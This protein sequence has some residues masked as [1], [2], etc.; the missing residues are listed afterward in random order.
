M[1]R[2]GPTFAAQ[3][4]VERMVA[5]IARAINARA[6][7]GAD[8]ARLPETMD[9]AI[10][11]VRAVCDDRRQDS[12][13]ILLLDDALVVDDRPLREGGLH[14]QPLIRTLQRCRIER[15][16]LARDTEA[17]EC[18]ELIDALTV[19]RVPR[20]SPHV[21]VGSLEIA[22]EQVAEEGGAA[23]LSITTAHIEAATD[24]FLQFRSHRHG[25]IGRL[26]EL[27]W[28]LID[29]VSR[30]SRMMLPLAP[31]RSHDEYTFVH[32]VNVALLVLAQ[33][34]SFGLQG[35][36]LHGIGVAAL[37]H[38]I[39]KLSI[40]VDVLN[41]PGRLEGEEWRIM[42]M[43][44]DLGARRLAEGEAA[45]PLSILVAYEHHLRYDGQPS[46]PPVKRPRR[47]TLASQLTTVADV[48]DAI[49]TARPYRK[50][51]SRQ[52]A[53]DVLR[54]R[55]GTFHDPFLVG[56]FFRLLGG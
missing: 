22:E 21:I 20:N 8:H 33:A 50:A 28:G 31:L 36:L 19:G 44:A 55:A 23:R 40:P 3:A 52:A 11:A 53:L 24:A 10:E 6:L 43:H 35:L 48:Y 18:G 46:Y 27:V 16:T 49:C 1:R 47:P 32:S 17:G 42:Q 25:A 4:R 14:Q 29:G 7:Y 30:S 34:R 13:T 45:T 9:S 37:L 2:E 51:L 56:N 41:K 38:D 5:L 26:E 15:V 39:G 54:E 12:V